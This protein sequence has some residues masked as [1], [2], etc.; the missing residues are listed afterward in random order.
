MGVG[1]WGAVGRLSTHWDSKSSAV[2]S[3][4]DIN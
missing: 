2:P 3:V 1:A 4:C